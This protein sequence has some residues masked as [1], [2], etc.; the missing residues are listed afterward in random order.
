MIRSIFNA[1][2]GINIA[3]VEEGMFSVIDPYP[4]MNED[5]LIE[6][7]WKTEKVHVLKVK[8][9]EVNERLFFFLPTTEIVPGYAQYHYELTRAGQT[10]PDDP[11]VVLTLRVKLDRPAGDDREQ[12][13][14]WHSALDIVGL[15]EDVINNG[16]TREWSAKGVPMT[17]KTY[18]GITV[19]DVI[20]VRWGGIFLEP[21]V[22]TQAEV[23]GSAQI[24]ITALPGDILTAGDSSALPI[25][26]QIH[27]EVWNYCE[28]WSKQTTVL[29]D[30]GAA[31]LDEA[32]FEDHDDGELHL[33]RLDHQATNLMIQ[34][35]N[36]DE[37]SAGDRIAI[38]IIGIGPPETASR[39][40]TVDVTVGNPPYILKFPI[41]YEF[42]SLF[43]MGTLDGSYALHKTDGPPPLY[44][45]RAFVDVIGNP[46][47]LPAPT[48]NEVLG[49]IL[50]VDSKGATVR[51]AYPSIA[52][53]D[54]INL[55][56]EGRKSD[57]TPYVHE[58]QH[59]IS[60]DDQLAGLTYIYVQSEHILELANGS[61]K[62]YYRV[63][64]EEA[65]RYG[66][67]ES[68]SLRVEIGEL[69]ATLPAPDVEE[70]KD[71]VIDPTQ[72][73]TQAHVLVKPVNWVKGDTL[74]YHWIGVTAYGSTRGSIPITVLNGDR[75]ARFRVD[76]EYV[77]TNIGY[78][79]TVLYT[80]LHAATGKYSYSAPFIVMIGVPLGRLLPPTVTKTTGAS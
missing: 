56:W 60:N 39:T 64:N 53:G 38:K 21:H 57:G 62:L 61:L 37:F 72:V 48:I 59:D 70:A 19:R 46:A 16:V 30:A 28:K 44:S 20:W 12:H 3:V 65:D 26:Y 74:T 52:V 1:D 63:Y 36:N 51:I 55:I 15:P 32:I 22:V 58:E 10:L 40:L 4:G 25:S 73:Y 45:E 77:T 80:L 7:F 33:D 8:R 49:A 67:S 17:I 34:V 79:V 9:E 13:L 68:D 42:V 69:R 35:K 23:D 54:T 6:I 66:I 75:T 14:P 78:P 29:V 11:S 27:D 5:D 18:P 47:Q 76:A 71:G 2:G 43:A 31:R 41:P 50:P 24:V